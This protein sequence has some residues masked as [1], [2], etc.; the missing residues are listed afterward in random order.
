MLKTVCTYCGIAYEPNNGAACPDCKPK[1]DGSLDKYVR[2]NS[3]KRGYG[4]R[5]AKLS[6]RAR[7]LQ[8]FCSD[9]GRPDDLTA[10]HSVEAWK[11]HD[12]GLPVRLRDVDVVCRDCNTDRGAARGEG[13][14]D[15][16]R[17]GGQ[18]QFISREVTRSSRPSDVDGSALEGGG[19]GRTDRC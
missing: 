14:T 8:P 2:G 19:M 18:V 5:W 9:C 1:D 4:Y 17:N 15:E 10:D 6:K 13:A 12:A 7:E 3:T 16:Y 11:R